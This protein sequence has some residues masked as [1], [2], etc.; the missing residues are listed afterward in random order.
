MAPPASRRLRLRAP[1]WALV[2]LAWWPAAVE[3]QTGAAPSTEVVVDRVVAI[4]GA[5]GDRGAELHIVTL[6]ELNVEARLVV[7]ERTS[8]L[9]S[10]LT[11]EITPGLQESVLAGIIDQLLL[12][13]EAQRLELAA[14]GPDDI[15]EER[16]ALA[17]R[18]GGPAGLDL[19]QRLTG[20][21]AELVNAI[22]QR[23]VV[24][25]QFM[26][27]HVRSVTPVSTDEV[28]ALYRNGDHP[29]GDRP[30]EEV[31]GSLEAILVARQRQEGLA[32][33]LA[34][35]RRR[36]RVRILPSP[37]EGPPALSAPSP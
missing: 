6:V 31:R 35:A 8:A 12:V 21:P 3:A 16:A 33:W 23:R 7:A 9:N 4:V 5:A 28:D 14:V 32:E 20:A 19:F 24:A 11:V 1:G 10:A 18:L 36:S 25:R 30:L 27:R 22:V 17:N 37:A 34:G 15:D 26:Q 29:F 13:A 2:L